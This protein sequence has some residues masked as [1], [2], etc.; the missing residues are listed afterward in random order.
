MLNPRW[1]VVAAGL[2]LLVLTMMTFDLVHAKASPRIYLIDVRPPRHT[3]QQIFV[4][5][6]VST[7]FVTP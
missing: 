3:G 4:Q 7:I 5:L 2:I 1:L 6:F